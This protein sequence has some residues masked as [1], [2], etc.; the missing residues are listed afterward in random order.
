MIAVEHIWQGDRNARIRL[1]KSKWSF[2]KIWK[3]TGTHITWMFIGVATGGAA[4]FYF[5][6]APTLMHQFLTNSAP[7]IAYVFVGIFAAST[8]VLGGMSREQVCTYMCP[9]PRIQ[10][11]MFDAESLLVTYRGF[12]GEPRGPHKK[13]QSWEGRGDCIDCKQCVAVCPMGI[14]IRNGP[15]LECI[16]CA[17]CID[18]CDSIM[19]QIG[20][21]T[22]LVAYDSYRNLE[23]ESH[24]ARA[25][26]RPFR[27]RTM[28]YAT[29]LAIVTG[30]MVLVFSHRTVLDVNVVPDRNPLFV[31]LSDGSIRNGY[32]VR[33]INKLY[34]TRNYSV[35]VEGLPDVKLTIAGQENVAQPKID[36]APDGVKAVKLFL[37]L[38][39]SAQNKLTK[40]SAT[41]TFVVRDLSDSTEAHRSTNFKGPDK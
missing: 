31:Q 20:R 11:A 10:G 16:Q 9:W 4:V 19:K 36:V 3:L 28:V 2:E 34:Q 37:S 13:G 15:Q 6:D 30:V 35:T 8:Y 33:I 5:A 25:P 12:R 17:L 14:D 32:T 40:G 24:G 23:A 18:A 7:A 1:A 38:P 26:I 39:R 41:I 27:P 29:V 22:K 21:P